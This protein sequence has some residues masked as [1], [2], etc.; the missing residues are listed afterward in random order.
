M[1]LPDLRLFSSHE[2]VII[3]CTILVIP[4]VTHNTRKA[5]FDQLL[6][7]ISAK[8]KSKYDGKERKKK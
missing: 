1:S 8:K 6:S 7:N 2:L 5:F 4:T 3:W